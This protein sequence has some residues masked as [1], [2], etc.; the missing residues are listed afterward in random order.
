MKIMKSIP[1]FFYLLLAVVWFFNPAGVPAGA[2]LVEYLPHKQAPTLR[3]GLDWLNT[4][5]PL[6]LADL[7][8]KFVLLNFWTY[9]SVNCVNVFAE[10]KALQKKYP[11]ELVIVGIHSPKYPVQRYTDN[12]KEAVI[13]YSLD[14]PV[15]NDASLRIW[16]DYDIHAW[17]T[18]ILI[19]PE[20]KI[21][22]KQIGENIYPAV[23]KELRTRISHGGY[24]IRTNPVSLR[25]ERHKEP[26]TSLL[27]PG[28]V[29]ATDDERLFI[30]DSGHNRI[31][32]TDGQGRIQDTIGSGAP[33][34]QD[35]AFETTR[36]TDP[37]GMVRQG[38]S[39][40]IADAG[41]HAIRRA[42]LKARKV[43]TIAGTGRRSL[44]RF[45]EG[46]GTAVDLNYPTDLTWVGEQLY[47]AMTGAHQIWT[48]DLRDGNIKV[49]AG[50][51][52]ENLLDG[53]LRKS[54]FA[55]P[56][57][58]VPSENAVYVLDSEVSA[59]RRVGLF[60]GAQVETM[61][62]KGLHTYGDEEG[63]PEQ[64]RLQHPLG[65]CRTPESLLIAD[66]YNNKI[67]VFSL[68]DNTLTTLSGDARRGYRDGPF[69][70]A[71]FNGPG[72]V[73]YMNNRVFIADTNNHCIRILDLE[74]KRVGTLSLNGNIETFLAE[75]PGIE[76]FKGPTQKIRKTFSN[77]VQDVTLSLKLPRGARILYD[78]KP[79][80]RLFT[81]SR[82]FQRLYAIY[83]ETSTFH[84][85]TIFPVETLYAEVSLTYGIQDQPA[86]TVEE[87]RVYIFSLTDQKPSG[88]IR[89]LFKRNTF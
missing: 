62:G 50:S 25:L 33:G 24:F 56:A 54:A 48:L 30:A 73:S 70:R 88:D 87:K 11:R 83:D 82:D 20:G 47:I 58:I 38:D 78:R 63:G 40:Y 35:G 34:L 41:N 61:A 2:G 1:R 39:L 18:V 52:I 9:S 67:R 3:T 77:D 22:H 45:P 6:T 51:G 86:Q 19:D 53:P 12:V 29:L 8:G 69:H 80:V 57:G 44:S 79:Y 4:E 84:V 85:Y 43:V 55:Q 65:L 10:L 81:A 31:L 76:D 32:I 14:Y 42:D 74:N 64:A 89:V 49:Y 68:S 37:Q 60:L 28:K 75:Q 21:V 13:R 46:A 16:R 72:G 71:L 15:V 5:A 17:P 59:I 27:F 26:L 66:T 7:K 36:F 23:D